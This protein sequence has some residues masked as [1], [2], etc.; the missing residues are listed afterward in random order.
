MTGRLAVELVEEALS[1]MTVI[2]DD[3]TDR[4]FEIIE[5][6]SGMR[7]EYDMLVEEYS[8]GTD[9]LNK[10]IGRCVKELMDREVLTKGVPSRRSSLIKT[11]SKLV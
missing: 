6:D 7:A 1:R 5:N 10:R 11:Y 8:G 9:T 3:V 4:V 2:D